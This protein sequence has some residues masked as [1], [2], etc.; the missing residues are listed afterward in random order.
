M[1]TGAVNQAPPR[2]N[3]VA[4]GGPQMPL[5]LRWLLPALIFSAFM[6]GASFLPTTINVGPF[7][8]LSLVLT[9]FF[10]LT[11][12]ANRDARLHPIS[13]LLLAIAA[14][15]AVSQ[16]GIMPENRVTGLVQ[17]LVLVN[18]FLVVTVL[19]NL[20]RSYRISPAHI[21]TMITYTTLIAGVWVIS[22]GILSGGN[23]QASGPFRNR[24]H[25]ASY[26]LT[27]FWMVVVFLLLPGV[28]QRHRWAGLAAASTCLYTIAIS[29]R[30]SVYLSL[31]VGLV[32][33]S[34]AFILARGKRL[35]TFAMAGFAVAFVSLFYVYGER[36]GPQGS[37]FQDRVGGVGERLR[38]FVDPEE[39]DPGG[40][41]ALQ[42]AGVK[43]AF[44]KRPIL[45]IGWGGFASSIYSP[46]GHEVHST[47]LRFLAE[48]GV[49]GL[50]LYFA[51]IAQLLVRSVRLF[52]RMRSTPYS[53]GYLALAVASWSLCVSYIYNRHIT[54]RTFWLFLFV[55]LAFE[56]L[57]GAAGP[58]G[59]RRAAARMPPTRAARH[60]LQAPGPAMLEAGLSRHT[61][62]PAGAAGRPWLPPQG[63]ARR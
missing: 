33:L 36:I 5:L 14:A 54:E 57:A 55:L 53:A 10:L 45:G 41:Y 19:F 43:H 4:L 20:A 15:A 31:F 61:R 39:V 50:L 40:F 12:E 23:I 44:F 42:R 22:S 32:C 37:F 24:A 13:K 38:N 63:A 25:T 47:P 26:M 60:P 18:L 56:L 16:I 27:A 34:I 8:V 49:V 21:L 35:R 1:T 2:P 6:S 9:G 30:R 52:L 3:V 46:T 11:P 59:Q 51:F 62:H 28:R 48:L 29:G 7:E 58:D 17:T